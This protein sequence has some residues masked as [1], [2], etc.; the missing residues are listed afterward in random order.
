MN[1]D[2]VRARDGNRFLSK[3][4]VQSAVKTNR[5]FLYEGSVPFVYKIIKSGFFL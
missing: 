1:N 2:S 3:R 4:S 5:S